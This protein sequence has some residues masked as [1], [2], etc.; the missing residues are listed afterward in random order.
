[1]E[2]I[3]ATAVSSACLNG[4]DG[5]SAVGIFASYCGS[6]PIL[7]LPVTQAGT[8]YLPLFVAIQT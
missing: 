1:M 8:T 5:N 2:T 4:A 7:T 6:T 3:I